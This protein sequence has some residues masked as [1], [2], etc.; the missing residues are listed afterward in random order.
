MSVFR[1]EY[2]AAL[3]LFAKVSEAMK[4]KGLNAPV[5]VGGAAVELYTGSAVT[6]GDFDIVT[7]C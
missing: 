6:T 3:Q 2:E 7:P 5:L 1:P 4:A